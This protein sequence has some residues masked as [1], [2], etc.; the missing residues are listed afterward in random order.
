MKKYKKRETSWN[1]G[2]KMTYKHGM[3]GKHHT[4]E[5]KQKL[6]ISHKGINNFNYGKN[7][8]GEASPAWKGIKGKCRDKQYVS[9]LKNKRNRMPKIGGHTWGEWKNLLI[10]YNYT[11]PFCQKS[12]PNISLTQDHI[13]PLSKGGSDN[14]ENIQPLCRSCNSKKHAR[15]INFAK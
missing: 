15:I 9:W 4:K 2:K 1:K 6:S 3:L 11:C 5:T 13:I 10:Q 7:H 14:I 12:E 8:S